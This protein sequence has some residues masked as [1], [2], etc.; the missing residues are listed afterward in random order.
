MK[1]LKISFIF[2]F[3]FFKWMFQSTAL[4][5]PGV[6]IATQEMFQAGFNMR[7]YSNKK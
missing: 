7:K 1:F 2:L 6:T 3:L 4:L 5:G